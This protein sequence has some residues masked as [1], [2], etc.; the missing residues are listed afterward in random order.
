MNIL[1]TGANGFIGKALCGRLPS[2]NKV[3]GVDIA[4]TH[5]DRAKV[6]WEQG[7]GFTPV[8]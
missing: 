4:K 8:R 3:I 2:G 6:T 5:D 7:V 1:I